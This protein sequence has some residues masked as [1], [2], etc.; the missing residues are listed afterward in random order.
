MGFSTWGPGLYVQRLTHSGQPAPEEPAVLSGAIRGGEAE[1][2]RKPL[3]VSGAAPIDTSGL[4]PPLCGHFTDRSSEF[5]ATHGGRAHRQSFQRAGGGG[6]ATAEMAM[7]DLPRNPSQEQVLELD[8]LLL[9]N[10]TFQPS[11]EEAEK[12][13]GAQTTNC[14]ASVT[15]FRRKLFANKITDI[16]PPKQLKG[17]LV[18]EQAW[19]SRQS[20]FC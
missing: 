10:P 8:I 16:D 13:H 2:G 6:R 9:I 5:V 12:D 14:T 11:N 4:W 1:L 3:E 18:N 15:S 17:R 7:T 20:F 19:I